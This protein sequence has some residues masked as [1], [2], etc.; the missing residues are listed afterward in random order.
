MEETFLAY[1]QSPIGT[2][3]I[4]GTEK[5]LN[6]ILFLN[7]KK[8]S[9]KVVPPLLEKCIEELDEY[10]NG[11][12]KIFNVAVAQE[13]T[14]FQQKVW[15]ELTKIPYGKTVSYLVIAKSMKNPKSI[16]AVGGA[17]GKN[18]IAIIIPCHRVIGAN[19]KLTGYAGGLWRKEWLLNHE[20]KYSPGQRKLF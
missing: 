6:E 15:N 11:K 1:Y 5:A 16:R 17:N 7:K 9:T 8:T 12:R 4:K 3:V 13:G 20:L 14:V 10:F 18:K 2:V 19:N